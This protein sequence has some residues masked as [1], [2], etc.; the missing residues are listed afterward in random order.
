MHL[1]T[2]QILTL[3]SPAVALLFSLG[4]VFAWNYGRRRAR[5]L[6]F[7]AAAF[8]VYAL[9]MASQILF[10]PPNAGANTLVS[11]ALYLISL[12][13]LF[14]GIA[15]RYRVPFDGMFYGLASIATLL[16][17]AYFYYAQWN[18]LARIYI[19]NFSVAGM[20]LL[21]VFRIRRISRGIPIDRTFFW[22]Y[23]LFGI[24]FVPRTILSI[25]KA[26][27]AGST[28]GTSPYW[29]VMQITLLLFMVV[30]AMVL[31]AGAMLDIISELQHD[32]NID[33][34]TKLHNRRS[35]EEQG[36][37]EIQRCR[38]ESICLVLCDLDHFKSINDTYGHHAGDTVLAEC[39][40]IIR[41]C[42]RKND[43][44]GRFGGEEFVVLMPN[45]T[46]VGAARFADRVREELAAADFPAMSV[47][48]PVT[49]SFGVAELL[50]G[51]TLSGLFRRADS[52]LYTAKNGGRNRVVFDRAGI[53][54]AHDP[55]D[56]SDIVPLR[57]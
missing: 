51:E 1:T 15:R 13:L 42:I 2:N 39:G 48:Q 12:F 45:T 3:T 55:E 49:A 23:L 31:L 18:L 56:M 41:R 19:L 17:L 43:I 4:F 7:L 33:D 26:A 36:R 28:I 30:L 32:R 54:L 8:S 53:G 34:L 40:N 16:A 14:R 21:S 6:L 25:T 35:F 27:S 22:I 50:P 44:A 47:G 24:S 5:Y 38:N 10:I 52:M 37:R 9:A 20:V 11:G 29:I 57:T 46:L